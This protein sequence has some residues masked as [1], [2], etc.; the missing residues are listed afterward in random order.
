MRNARSVG[1]ADVAPL[2]IIP[3]ALTKSPHLRGPFLISFA[4]S[5]DIFL[6]RATTPSQKELHA[7]VPDPDVMW[8]GCVGRMLKEIRGCNEVQLTP[9]PSQI[10]HGAM[11]LTG[12]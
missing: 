6:V 5:E 8:L 9:P 7:T 11:R 4:V 2:M 1:A 3:K 10:V 12:I